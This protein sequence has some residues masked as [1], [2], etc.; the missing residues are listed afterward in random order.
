[1]A[2]PRA[3][4]RPRHWKGC[5]CTAG[6][7]GAVHRRPRAQELILLVQERLPRASIWVSP[8]PKHC[9]GCWRTGGTPGAGH[10]RPTAQECTLPLQLCTRLVAPLNSHTGVGCWRRTLVFPRPHPH[11]FHG[12]SNAIYQRSTGALP[13][14]THLLQ[15]KGA[16]PGLTLQVCQLEQLAHLEP[17]PPP[18]SRSPDAAAGLVCL[19]RTR[20]RPGD[21]S[22][23]L[24][25][26]WPRDGLPQLAM[27]SSQRARVSGAYLWALGEP[28][29]RST[30]PSQAPPTADLRELARTWAPPPPSCP[31]PLHLLRLQ[32]SGVP[33]GPVT[34]WPL[35]AEGLFQQCTG[36]DL[37]GR[38][39]TGG[40]CRRCTGQ[41]P[42]WGKM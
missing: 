1:M 7:P 6:V 39:G 38:W 13:G 8:K 12:P 15:S 35:V 2:G 36:R 28:P 29:G 22:T 41:D 30:E 31:D 37:W 21:P 25:L 16:L 19:G 11:G 23:G 3:L 18:L 20:G 10:Q 34:G 14:S 32:S 9:R 27:A 5:W 26:A 40:A 17:P 33:Q 24:S 4:P 42:P